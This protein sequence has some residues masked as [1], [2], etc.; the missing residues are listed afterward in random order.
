M[1]VWSEEDSVEE[2]VYFPLCGVWC[3]AGEVER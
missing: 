3:S 2:S 1:R